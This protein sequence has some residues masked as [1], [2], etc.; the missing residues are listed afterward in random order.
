MSNE[1][2][3]FKVG[4]FEC[5]ADRDLT[6]TYV[7]SRFFAN[8][9]AKSLERVLREHELEPMRIPS[10]FTCLYIDTGTAKVLADT[11]A[12]KGVHPETG[13]YEGMLLKTLHSE[14]MEA[15][16]IDTVIL[17]HAHPDHVGGNIDESGRPVFANARYVVWRDEWDF[18][19]SESTLETEPAHRVQIARGKLL[20]IEGQ[21]DLVDHE[22]EIV[23][24]IHAVGAKGHTPGHMAVAV[25]PGGEQLIY[26]SDAALHQIHLEHP[27]WLTNFHDRDLEQAASTRR[28]L[29]DRAA[30]ETALVF[31]APFL[32]IPKSGPRR[33]R[34]QG[35]AVAAD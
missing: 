7:A 20:P 21:L 30:A 23:L 19:T 35:M 18:W 32:S 1:S 33:E 28:R 22:A 34:R 12:G 13:P 29:F 6:H 4:A 31:G 3:R 14:G 10:P 26:A 16:N 27:E 11:G 24:G 15:E 25:S 8:A 17:T 5:I 2:H 9:P